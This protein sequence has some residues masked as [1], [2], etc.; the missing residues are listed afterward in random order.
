LNE[1]AKT[2]SG[3]GRQDRTTYVS[4]GFQSMAGFELIMYGHF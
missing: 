4:D 1:L 3:S 2:K